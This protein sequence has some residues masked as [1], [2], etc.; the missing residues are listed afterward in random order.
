MA[1]AIWIDFAHTEVDKLRRYQIP[2]PYYS[3]FFNPEVTAEHLQSI[4][5][6]G[7]KP[8]IYSAWNWYPDA[9]GKEY[10][11]IV[12]SE[13]LRIGWKGNPPVCIDIETHDVGYILDCLTRWRQ[14]RPTRPTAWT[15]EGYQGGLFSPAVIEKLVKLNVRFVPQLYRGDMTPHEHSPILDLLIQGFPGNR[16]DGFYDAARLPH[17]WR[18]FAFT[19][20]RLP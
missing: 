4:A 12:H 2:H 20:A 15:F 1:R 5:N 9:S 8:G 17:N 19:Q 18:G 11:E 16:I 10:A 6:Q 14:L 13:L 7:F 3:H